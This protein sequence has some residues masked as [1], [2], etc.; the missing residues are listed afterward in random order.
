MNFL[1]LQ[2]IIQ[3]KT[4]KKIFLTDFAKILECGK[5]NISN[6]AKNSSEITVSELQKIERYFGIS[7]YYNKIE[8]ILE[9]CIDN[10]FQYDI[11]QWGKRLL[12]L[13]IASKM[14]DSKEFAKF[15]NIS[16]KRLDEFIRKN[17]FP[18]GKE[19]LKIKS[20]FANTDL[21]WLLFGT[22]EETT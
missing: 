6:R 21:N 19:L 8:P 14:Y 11:E 3:K 16:E 17:K 9:P 18:E 12:M 2:E 4:N 22:T 10:S 1:E 7:L 5:A 15:L 20:K 13:Q